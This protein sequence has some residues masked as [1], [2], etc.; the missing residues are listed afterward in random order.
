[1]SAFIKTLPK[2]N[3]GYAS[4]ATTVKAPLTLHGLGG[5]YA[6]AL[7]TAAHKSKTLDA[8]EGDLKK[9]HA[10]YLKNDSL[11]VVLE[12][13]TLN[14]QEKKKSLY[15]L[16]DS[17][18][19][20]P[21]TRN[22]FEL[23]LENRRLA[24]TPKIISAFLSLMSAHRGELQITVT[25]A[26][27]LDDATMKQLKET[28]SKGSVSAGSKSV[29]ISNQVKPTILGGLI[30]EFGDKTIDL[31]ISSKVAKLRKVLTDTI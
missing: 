20:S 25:S 26:Q 19:V 12:D 3:R 10:A 28:L 27:T 11:K 9:F 8:V 2:L 4:A 7:Y 13:P 16:L 14:K 30:I 6:T 15:A 24:E 23:L 18:K 5:R 17:N 29:T 21:T 1:M 31:S 22:L